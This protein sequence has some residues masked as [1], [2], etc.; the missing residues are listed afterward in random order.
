[1][2]DKKKVTWDD[3]SNDEQR[4]VKQLW[5]ERDWLSTEPVPHLFN[6]VYGRLY[7]KGLIAP[8][9]IK[10][11]RNPEYSYRLTKHGME[12]VSETSYAQERQRR[13]DLMD[14]WVNGEMTEDQ[15][16]DELGKVQS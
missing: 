10:S 8:S 11:G 2:I 9:M 4:I 15:F 16:L 6:G 5:D 3:L 7:D 14:K 12:L 1:M 13:R